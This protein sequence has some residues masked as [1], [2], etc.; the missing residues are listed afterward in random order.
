MLI[1]KKVFADKGYFG[2]PNREFLSL[3]KIEDV[4]DPK[5]H[6]REATTQTELT[7]YE[8]TRN[9]A[10]SKV[11]YILEQY[12]GISHLYNKAYRARFP[13]MIKNAVDTLFRQLAFNIF[14][15]TKVVKPAQRVEACVQHTGKP[16]FQDNSGRLWRENGH[17]I[18]FLTDPGSIHRPTLS[19][20]S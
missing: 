10:I 13:K 16:A 4:M 19:A 15:G 6:K 12:F 17:F 8:E 2:K 18:I 20:D 7:E 11:R 3:N 14:R 9:K 5:G 1:I